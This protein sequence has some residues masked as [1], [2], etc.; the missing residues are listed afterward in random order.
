MG[1]AESRLGDMADDYNMR[2]NGCSIQRQ[3]RN[4]GG[5]GVILYVRNTLRVEIL[6]SLIPK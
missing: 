3:I 6:P 1:V 4:T 5:G 2:V